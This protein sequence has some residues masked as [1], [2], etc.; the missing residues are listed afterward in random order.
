MTEGD[1]FML[2]TVNEAA[3]EL[4]CSPENLRRQI[5]LG[6]LPVYRIGP[7]TQRVDLDEVRKLARREPTEA[8]GK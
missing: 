5:R 1:D 7:R 8:T 2:L 4:R 3:R 6:R